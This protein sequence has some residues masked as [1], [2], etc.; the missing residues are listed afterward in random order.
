MQALGP[1]WALGVLLV[2]VTLGCI[3]TG[4]GMALLYSLTGGLFA[5]AGMLALRRWFSGRRLW[6][7]SVFCAM[8]SSR[9]FGDM[10]VNAFEERID[11]ELEQQ[12]AAVTADLSDG[13]VYV[14]FRG[15]DDTLVGRKGGLEH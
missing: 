12:F 7:L 2:R 13:S 10:L 5:Y 6:I 3:I 15:T 11:N 9:R 8:A 1:G 14:S 4:Q